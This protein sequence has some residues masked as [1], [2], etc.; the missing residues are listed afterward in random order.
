MAYHIIALDLDGTLLTQDKQILPQSLDALNEAKK[1]GATILIVTG[2]HHVTIRPFYHALGLTTPALCCNGTYTYDVQAQKVLQQNPLSLTQSLH[3][4]EK[5]KSHGIDTVMYTEDAMTYEKAD[6]SI[7]RWQLWS[8][9]QQAHLRPT[10]RQVTTFE[11]AARESQSVW[12]FAATSKDN[13]MLI[14]LGH[15]LEETFALSCEFSWHN[16][17]DI[18]QSGNSKGAL[19]RQWVESN[20]YSM[21]DVIAFGDN[22]NDISMIEQAGL[23]VAMGNSADEIKAHADIVT[24]TNEEPGIANLLKQYLI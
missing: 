2:R 1:Q 4:I 12:K 22:Y 3:V 16:Q 20:G 5:L 18:A 9:K 8:S 21:Q 24:T 19:L 6:D 11:D 7:A 14:R 10:I 23:G 13:D 17:M 15:E